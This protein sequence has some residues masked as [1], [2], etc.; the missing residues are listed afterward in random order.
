MRITTPKVTPEQSIARIEFEILA[1]KAKEY[2]HTVSVP[3]N[4]SIGEGCPSV[5]DTVLIH[6]G[7]TVKYCNYE[8]TAS[9]PSLWSPGSPTLYTASVSLM[10]PDGAVETERERFGFRD[11]TYSADSGFCLNGKHMLI[12]GACVHHDNGILGAASYDDAEIRKAR[13]LKGA[14]FNAVRTSHNPPAPAFLDACDSIGL[15]VIDEAFD[16]WKAQKNE[17]DYN[18]LIDDWWRE[19]IA[20]LVERDRNHPSVIAWSIGNEIIERKS[21]DAVKRAADLGNLCRQ[22]DDTRPVTQALAAWDPDW[23]IYDPLA[24][25]HEII[26]YNYMLHKAEGDHN[27]V[28]SR[29]IWQTE[30][31][32]RDA[33]KNWEK[34]HDL[35]YVIGD[36]VWTGIDYIGESGIGRYWYE[37][38]PEGEHYHRPLWPWHNSYCGDIDIIGTR[39]PISFY[40]E[41][42]Y[43]QSPR[44]HLSVR[45]P[46]GYKGK[47]KEGLWA[48]YP[49]KDSWNWPGHEGLPIDIEIT[50]SY[51]AVALYQ[52]GKLIGKYPTDRQNE[53]KAV[54]T[55]TYSPGELRA[56]A[57]DNDRTEVCEQMLVTSGKPYAIRLT[58]D[59]SEFSNSPQELIY[60][61]AEIVD[62]KG[63]PVPNAEIP[64]TFS[65]DGDAEI[66]AT[67]SGNPKDPQGYFHK[68][69]TTH[70]GKALAVIKSSISSGTVRFSAKGH[71]LKPST[72]TFRNN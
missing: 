57:L 24:A 33:F 30:S 54:V 39:K 29:V 52:D 31:Y 34:V 4:L 8:I 59:K 60:I 22:M 50:S 25:K 21:P 62:K 41:I 18:Q 5:T 47:V 44:M 1:P 12:T 46:Q 28:P 14:G 42:L 67:G 70:E 43:S 55:L 56:V 13:L 45:E 11:I 32:P 2:Q 53:Y 49:T 17:Y 38:D 16:G 19:D 35:P 6:P 23:E 61:L 65:I 37:G 20:S 26:G 40:R 66:L 7:E 68:K 69:R 51:P 71:G 15:L 27:R 10:L 9:R 63:N 36:F 58:P 72:V 64:I 3:L 48:V